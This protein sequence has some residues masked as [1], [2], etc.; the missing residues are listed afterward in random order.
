[1]V[2]KNFILSALVI[3]A[4]NTPRP[5]SAETYTLHFK[6]AHSLI[7]IDAA[8][9]GLPAKLI[10]DTGA[11]RTIL[12]AD[13]LGMNPTE[14]EMQE[15]QFPYDLERGDALE[16][17]VSLILDRYELITTRTYVSDLADVRNLLGVRCDGILGQDIISSFNAIRVDYR[18]SILQLEK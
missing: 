2:S 15:Q 1:M 11:T 6:T 10:F 13:I 5:P 3:P 9:N 8:V 4:K 12:S 14:I 18:S 16:T 7:L 17:N